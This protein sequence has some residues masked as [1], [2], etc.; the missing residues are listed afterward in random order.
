[1]KECFEKTWIRPHLSNRKSDQSFAIEC[2]GLDKT[3][4]SQTMGSARCHSSG[5]IIIIFS[6]V[7]VTNTCPDLITFISNSRVSLQILFVKPRYWESPS[8]WASRVSKRRYH[9]QEIASFP[10]PILVTCWQFI[11][12]L[13]RL[14]F[15]Q[16]AFPRTCHKISH[17]ES[18]KRSQ[19]Q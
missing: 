4:H 18:N 13:F 7:Q 12:L 10:R 19:Q 17:Q 9:T 16:L 5:I 8:S 14:A 15:G 6:R 3:I 1:M 11:I 2:L